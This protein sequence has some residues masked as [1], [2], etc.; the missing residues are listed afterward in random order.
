[1]FSVFSKVLGSESSCGI[2]RGRLTRAISLL[3]I[4]PIFGLLFAACPNPSTTSDIITYTVEVVWEQNG[5]TGIRFVFSNSIDNLNVSAS[6]INVTGAAT[7]GSTTT[8]TKESDN[9]WLLSPITV[10]ESGTAHITITKNDIEDTIKIVTVHRGGSSG[11]PTIPNQNITYTIEP[12][13]DQDGTTGIRFVFSSS[14]TS[15]NVSAS[16]INVTG[17]AEKGS[18]TFSGF[19]NNWLLSPITVNANGL[20]SVVITKNGIEATSK[21]VNVYI[22]GSTDTPTIP[23]QNITYTVAPVGDGNADTT[24]IRFIFSSSIDNL[25]VSIA[26]ISVTGAATKE[27]TATFTKQS[28]NSWLL[29]PITVTESDIAYITINKAGIEGE[30]HPV[31]VHKQ[32]QIDPKV[33]TITWHLNNGT[34]KTDSQHLYK[35]DNGATLSKPNDPFKDWY[36]FEGWYFDAGLTMQYNFAN[37]VN[38]DLHLYAKWEKAY[39]NVNWELNGGI[40]GTDSSHPNR[41]N[42][43]AT[44]T[45][46]TPDP[47][48]DNYAFGG[49][50]SDMSLT[51]QYNFTNAVNAK[52]NLYAKWN[53]RADIMA[54]V[55]TELQGLSGGENATNPVKLSISIPAVF[56]LDADNWQ[57]WRDLLGVIAEVG[58]FVELD[59]STCKMDG[60]EIDLLS[61]VSTGKNR[62]VT[63]ILPND[64][65]SL[66][67]GANAAGSVS[68][69]FSALTT[70]TGNN[71]ITVNNHAFNGRTA[72]VTVNL[73]KATTF[74]NQTFNNCTALTSVNLPKA[75]TF[76]DFTF[77]GCTALVSIELPEA[78]TFGNRTF[79]QT[80][81]L[82]TVKLPKVAS[83]G[84]HTFFPPAT[85]TRPTWR[86]TPLTVYMG[87]KAP[88]VGAASF[89]TENLGGTKLVTVIV[90]TNAEG[91]GESPTVTNTVNWGNGFRGRGWTGTGAGSGSANS[92]INLTIRA[93]SH[94]VKV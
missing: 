15:L 91:Y 58:K 21:T 93:C 74:G 24:G 45:K 83:F 79:N 90:P 33:W 87:S 56:S 44:L 22:G 52:L 20:A 89:S 13:G 84:T 80:L 73:P 6:D 39:W 63:I 51:T 47:T 18:A 86:D 48:K 7:K 16:D 3:A 85:G 76:G 17:T 34:W 65:T 64:A 41:V 46:P 54:K 26:A 35:I 30:S 14:I 4:I 53:S 40:W 81:V 59:L 2:T 8:F 71:I 61:N 62:I 50:Y 43:G 38:A 49:W 66:R 32:G 9:N 28:D 1:M 55:R 36:K 60:T 88:I 19:N 27:S 10:T 37:A 25:N 82:A 23:I 75:T 12:V 42:K 68:N 57:V 29:S 5:T 67:A 70:V 92:G 94:N 78:T 69:N 72:L 11:T 77:S 31:L